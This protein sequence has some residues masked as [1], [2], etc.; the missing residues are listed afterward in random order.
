[1]RRW[2]RSSV[3]A[4]LAASGL[5]GA[6]GA[7][8]APAP[9]AAPVPTQTP[10]P[11]P[12]ATAAPAPA[13]FR[14]F[15]DPGHGGKPEPAS[16][17][18]GAHFDP[19]SGRF[20]NV[21]SYG[22]EYRAPGGIVISEQ[23][24]V[25]ALAR[26]IRERLDWT[27]TED[28]WERFQALLARFGAVLPPF[29]RVM[30]ETRLSRENDFRSHPDAGRRDVNKHFRIF[31]SPSRIPWDPS[32]PMQEGRLSKAAAFAPD[33]LLSLH[34]DGSR[35]R[36]QRGMSALFVP[37]HADFELARRIALG[38]A[39][40]TDVAKKLR[41]WWKYSGHGRD[42][43]QWML[44]DCWTYFTGYR[45]DPSG[46]RADLESYIGQRWQHVRWAYAE[47]VEAPPRT[48][49]AGPFTGRWFERERSAYEGFRRGEG[50]EEL[51]G[52]NLYAG[53]ELI[54][55]L[56][57]AL[58][59]DYS[60]G[61]TAFAKDLTPRELLPPHEKPTG[62]DWAMPLFT[63][64]VAPY[65]ELGQLWNSKDRF[66][67]TEKL[68]VMADAL[69]VGIYSLVTGFATPQLEGV[70]SPK[71]VRIEWERYRLPDGRTWSEAGRKAEE[72]KS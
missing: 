31:D 47:D 49:L 68:D 27:R 54:R 2:W 3:L 52:D 10:A 24:Q 35:N 41:H 1:M 67:L 51:G 53:Q 12:A 42:K 23:Q 6:P 5:P 56:R 33:L 44:N 16:T 39:K 17:R 43:T 32:V 69:A 20:L 8:P 7:L 59:K 70:D 15:L 4:L 62:S 25:L 29:H 38:T 46:S 28:G 34:I 40:P 63:N 26:K 30:F 65:L 18:G 48:S 22:T 13:A 61:G 58:W 45:S 37:S 9:A 57:Y 71:G 21:Y 14:V 19:L 66:L 72:S 55:F 11:T 50:P 64:A 36:Q 60:D